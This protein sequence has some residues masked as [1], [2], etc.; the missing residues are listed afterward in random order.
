MAQR[1]IPY[2]EV[3]YNS[4]TLVADI[5]TILQAD[6]RNV[7]VP[8]SGTIST[9]NKIKSPIR[10]LAEAQPECGLTLFGYPEWQTYTRES[11]VLRGF[12]RIKH[13]YLHQ[14]LCEQPFQRGGRFLYA[15]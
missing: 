14:F 10:M 9:L 4:E 8:S 15:L 13:L 6:K 11:G 7:I 3:D 12:L 1:N 2:S 5:D